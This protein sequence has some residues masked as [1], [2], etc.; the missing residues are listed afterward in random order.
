MNLLQFL[1]R[2]GLGSVKPFIQE[3]FAGPIK[4][5]LN[6]NILQVTKIDLHTKNKKRDRLA[7][8]NPKVF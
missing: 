4:L 1:V 2:A 3:I 7:S 6:D 5:E 8:D